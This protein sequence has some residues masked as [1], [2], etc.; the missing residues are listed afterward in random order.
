MVIKLKTGTPSY[1]PYK[2]YISDFL[3]IFFCKLIEWCHFVT[4]L[5]NDLRTNDLI[6]MYL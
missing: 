1:I 4:Y 5:W 6:N 3:F 2:T